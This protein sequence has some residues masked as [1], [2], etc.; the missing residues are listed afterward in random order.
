MASMRLSRASSAMELMVSRLC[1]MASA[2]CWMKRSSRRKVASSKGFFSSC[3]GISAHTSFS[4]RPMAGKSSTT[5]ARRSTEFA[6]AMEKGLVAV[7]KNS[8][9]TAAWMA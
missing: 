5:M 4:I 9:P 7:F 6:R 8:K 3:S 1:S 2:G